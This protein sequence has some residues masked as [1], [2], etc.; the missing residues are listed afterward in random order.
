VAE[1]YAAACLVGLA[2]VY[3]GKEAGFEVEEWLT[4]ER[5]AP[6]S[7]ARAVLWPYRAAAVLVMGLTRLGKEPAFDAVAPGLFL[8]CV[9]FQADREKLRAAGVS[10][11]LNLCAEFRGPRYWPGVETLRVPLLD[12]T[13]PTP[14]Q[15]RAAVDWVAGRRGEGKIVLIHCAQGHGRS[16]TVAAACL[17]ALGLADTPD[18]AVALVRAAR[19]GA[20]PSRRQREA[21]ERFAGGIGLRTRPNR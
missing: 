4:S 21:L 6:S 15:L 12:G 9:P 19:P 18:A 7:A 14:R 2:G 8:G 10:A 20:R 17:C 5:S 16:A 13:A 11:V 3:A 1:G